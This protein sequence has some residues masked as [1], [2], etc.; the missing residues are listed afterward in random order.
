M[1]KTDTPTPTK[2]TVPTSTA[3][4][5]NTPPATSTPTKT[6]IPTNTPL[7]SATPIPTSTV[8]TATPAGGASGTYLINPDCNPWARAGQC[9]APADD[10]GQTC[11]L[12]RVIVVPIIDGFTNGK[13][14]VEIEGFAL[15][16]LDGFAS[17][18]CSGNDCQVIGRFVKADISMG[19]LAYSTGAN[20]SCVFD[21]DSLHPVRTA[22]RIMAARIAPRIVK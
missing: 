7:G 12:T 15:M 3:T 11:S 18:G 16:Y 14:P 4:S 1:P 8:P 20:I 22:G 19:A 17:G 10:S 21:P 9:P 2:T 6:A 13:K 5:T